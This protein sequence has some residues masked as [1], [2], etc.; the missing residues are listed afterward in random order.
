LFPCSA[1]LEGEYGLNDISL[2]VPCILGK[3]GIEKSLR[4]L[5]VM[6]KRQNWR[7]VQKV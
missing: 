3:S 1:L 5:L 2:G 7:R 4:S 6:Q